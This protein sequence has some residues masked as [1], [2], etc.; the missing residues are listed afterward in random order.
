MKTNSASLST[1]KF[2]LSHK[3]FR[4]GNLK[5]KFTHTFLLCVPSEQKILILQIY[6]LH[7]NDE[8]PLVTAVLNM[9][10]SELDG[11]PDSAAQPAILE[12]SSGF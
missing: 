7:E 9:P 2:L 10:R 3:E 1:G 8:I 4:L 11:A 5:F 12:P 6:I